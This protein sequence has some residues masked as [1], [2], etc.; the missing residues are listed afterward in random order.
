MGSNEEKKSGLPTTNH[1][2]VNIDAAFIIKKSVLPTNLKHN[3]CLY[4]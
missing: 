1:N 3:F 4:H 2:H